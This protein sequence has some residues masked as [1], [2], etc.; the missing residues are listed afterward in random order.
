MQQPGAH[1]TPRSAVRCPPHIGES[2]LEEV[3]LEAK[4]SS[5]PPCVTAVLPVPLWPAGQLE[6]GSPLLLA[7]RGE[8]QS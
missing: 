1:E 7:Q 4:S 8:R 5:L 6:I 2:P 3:D